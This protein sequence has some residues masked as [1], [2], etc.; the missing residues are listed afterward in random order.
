[1]KY[2]LLS[3]V[4]RVGKKNYT[5]GMVV[6][7]SVKLDKKFPNKFERIME[8]TPE[9]PDGVSNEDGD[10]KIAAP[11]YEPK[12]KGAGKWIVINATSPN[13]KQVNEG[14]L[15]KEEASQMAKDMNQG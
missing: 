9:Y 14:Y 7:S 12:H 8:F 1:M 10:K 15:D 4:H 2:K 6:E 3:G 5:K 13:E 11:R